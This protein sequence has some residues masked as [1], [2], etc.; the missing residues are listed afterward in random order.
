MGRRACSVDP[1]ISKHPFSKAPILAAATLF[2]IALL[3]AGQSSSIIATVAG[4]AVSE[5]FLR[6]RVSVSTAHALTWRPPELGRVQPVI[7]RL[8]TRLIAL[9][10]SMV[11]AIAV[12]RS[13][14]DALLVASQVTLSIVLPFISLPLIYLTSSKRIMSVKRPITPIV[15][16]NAAPADAPAEIAIAGQDVERTEEVVDFSNGKIVIAICS[17]IW[18]VV[19]T[20][21]VYVIVSLGLGTEG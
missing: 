1:L 9:I 19:V 20:A 17:G 8:A 13:G 14:I 15:P 2:A 12:G 11:V 7:R 16:E 5:G 10:P 18:L 6:W 21:N 4:Q 3:A